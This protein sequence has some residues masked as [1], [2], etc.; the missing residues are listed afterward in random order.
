MML[1]N[2]NAIIYGA[3][4]AIGGAVARAFAGEGA[5]I[6]L[7]GRHLP[8]VEAVANDIRAAG[9]AAET[10]QVNALDEEAVETHASAMLRKA[11]SMD[12]AFNA[13]TPIPLPGNA[14]DP[15]RATSG[16]GIS[17]SPGAATSV[18]TPRRFRKRRMRLLARSTI[19]RKHPEKSS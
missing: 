18:M 2:K 12:I 4:G 14:G 15:H 1:R 16:R 10:A 11:G 3:G 17:P 5:K 6:F 8:A 19:A 9:G 7:T 13:I